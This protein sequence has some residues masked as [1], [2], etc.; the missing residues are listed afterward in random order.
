VNN[1]PSL[2][3]GCLFD[4]IAHGLLPILVSL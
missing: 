3:N 2:E 1:V 4:V